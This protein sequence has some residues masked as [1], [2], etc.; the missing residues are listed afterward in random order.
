MSTLRTNLLSTLLTLAMT[1]AACAD[2]AAPSLRIVTEGRPNPKAYRDNIAVALEACQ[3]KQGLAKSSAGLPSES[4]LASFKVKEEERLLDGPLAATYETQSEITPDPSQACKLRIARS[5]HVQVDKSC[6]WRLYGNSGLLG[7]DGPGHASPL[8]EERTGVPGC[9]VMATIRPGLAAAQAKAPR[10]DAGLGQKC[11]WDGE[12]M[13][14]LAG[15]SPKDAAEGSCLLADLPVYPYSSYQGRHRNIALTHHLTD[16]TRGGTQLAKHVG[17]V[18]GI[19]NARL[20]SFE[21]GRRIPAD[22]FSR[23]GAEAFLAQPRWVN[24]GD[25]K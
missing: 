13:A 5:F 12:V 24:L 21:K 10:H 3:L 9:K 19:F 15:E 2:A 20:A 17:A 6:E 25:V 1:G 7:E 8:T 22:R 14:I 11:I 18:A 23:S 16:D 4:F